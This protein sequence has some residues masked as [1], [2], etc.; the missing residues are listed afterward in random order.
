MVG[1]AAGRG[2]GPFVCGVVYSF[3]ND[4]VGIGNCGCGRHRFDCGGGFVFWISNGFVARCFGG[5]DW[6]SLFVLVGLG[7]GK[8]LVLEVL[9]ALARAVPAERRTLPFAAFEIWSRKRAFQCFR[10]VAEAGAF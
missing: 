4:C 7:R 1:D 3:G 9:E 10:A 5:G 8:K 2:F 6:G